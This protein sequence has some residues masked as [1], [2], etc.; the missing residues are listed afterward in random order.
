M[1][2]IRFFPAWYLLVSS[3]LLACILSVLQGCGICLRRKSDQRAGFL[4]EGKLLPDFVR[5]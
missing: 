1:E 5:M 4:V 2:T 3:A